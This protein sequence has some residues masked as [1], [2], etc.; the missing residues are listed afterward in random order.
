MH[1][2]WNE[3]TTSKRQ[4]SVTCNI[5]S[6]EVRQ[7]KITLRSDVYEPDNQLESQTEKIIDYVETKLVGKHVIRPNSMS[8][9]DVSC[10]SLKN[11]TEINE[12]LDT[13]NMNI[14]KKP[15]KFG[16]GLCDRIVSIECMKHFSDQFWSNLNHIIDDNNIY[17]FALETSQNYAQVEFISY[18]YN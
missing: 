7:N 9:T 4:N 1:L 17:S 14:I 15:I 18:K 5:D 2:N 8:L 12:Q 10:L 13:F 3:F 11:L 16:L 6:L